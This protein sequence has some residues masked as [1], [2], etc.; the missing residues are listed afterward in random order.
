MSLIKEDK[1]CQCTNE[2]YLVQENQQLRERLLRLEAENASLNNKVI[3]KDGALNILQKETN[4]ARIGGE[5]IMG[6]EIALLQNKLHSRD[7]A[8]DSLQ[9]EVNQLRLQED[10]TFKDKIESLEQENIS[11]G[12]AIDLLKKGMKELRAEKE[13]QIANLQTEFD[14]CERSTKYFVKMLRQVEEEKEDLEL[15]IEDLLLTTKEQEQ[16]V[17]KSSRRI[18]SLKDRLAFYEQ[19]NDEME[20][21]INAERQEMYALQMEYNEL[22]EQVDS[23]PMEY[24][25]LLTTKQVDNNLADLIS[26]E[27]QRDLHHQSYSHQSYSQTRAPQTANNTLPAK[28]FESKSKQAIGVIEQHFDQFFMDLEQGL[29]ELKSSFNNNDNNSSQ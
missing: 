18:R 12:I 3:S 20:A 8:I 15:R 28:F 7:A 24:E 23:T 14:K 25:D 16:R 29:N 10:R 17:K 2:L 21:V 19:A 9:R 6:E 13:K 4:S 5:H 26:H 11:K 1:T 22:A 27:R